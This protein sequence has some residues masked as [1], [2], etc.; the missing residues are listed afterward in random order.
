MGKFFKKLVTPLKAI[1]MGAGAAAATAV[2]DQVSANP[3]GL[4]TDPKAHG[5]QLGIVA[6]VAALAYLKQSP[7]HTAENP[8]TVFRP[9]SGDAAPGSRAP[10]DVG[11]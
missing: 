3:I 4:M 11:N 1:A 6:I 8:P 2:I 7:I 9:F 5:K 10:K